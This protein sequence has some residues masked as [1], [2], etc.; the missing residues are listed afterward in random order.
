MLQNYPLQFFWKFPR[1]DKECLDA[2]W[3]PRFPKL[4]FMCLI[5]LFY[6]RWCNS[7]D[8]CMLLLSEWTHRLVLVLP[9]NYAYSELNSTRP[10]IFQLLIA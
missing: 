8:I 2:Q 6:P 10:D 1:L 9:F 4:A 3:K 7:P 5:T